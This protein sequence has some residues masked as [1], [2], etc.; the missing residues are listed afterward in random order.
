MGLERVT[1][2]KVRCF[3]IRQF[4]LSLEA[5]ALF[6]ILLPLPAQNEAN[7]S[8]QLEVE[9][10]HAVPQVYVDI[11]LRASEKPI[12]VPYCGESEGG[13]KVLCT[14]ATHLEVKTKDGWRPAKLRITF[15]VLGALSLSH[16]RGVQI[17]PKSSAS[18]S[19]QF[20]RRFFEVDSGQ[21]L[22]VRV[23]AWSDEQSMKAGRQ[24]TQFISPPFNCPETGTGQ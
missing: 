8:A 23:D 13:E 24:P 20:S 12:F 4:A 3:M 7:Q 19:F 16:A 2:M 14:V 5:M 17:A 1:E 18:F 15:G 6:A 22:R 10:V 9:N 21:Q 11:R